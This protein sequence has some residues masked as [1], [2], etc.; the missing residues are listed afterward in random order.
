MYRRIGLRITLMQLAL[1]IVFLSPNAHAITQNGVTCNLFFS[2]VNGA[3]NWPINGYL[4]YCGNNS[5]SD[6][7]GVSE[8]WNGAGGATQQVAT[9]QTIPFL[10]QAFTNTQVQLYVFD[11]VQDFNAY[12]NVSITPPPGTDAAGFTAKRGQV[13]GH[14]GPFSAIFQYA[15]SI[16]NSSRLLDIVQTTNHELGHEM[17]RYYNYPSGALAPAT[18]ASPNYLKAVN[19]DIV[20]VNKLTC[21][22]VFGA[23]EGQ[24]C[25]TGLTNWQRMQKLW[26]YDTS[27]AE[28]FANVFAAESAGGALNAQLGSIILNDFV[29]TMNYEHGL[30]TGTGAR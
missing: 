7:A 9:G 17:D 5:S 24:A 14:P 28:F 27:A 19:L 18:V 1:A 26:P 2:I 13:P 15:P 23:L 6:A 22:E 16:N 11:T 10:R 4:Y 8:V 3:I 29:N 20:Y 21:L 30:R 12:F 25:V